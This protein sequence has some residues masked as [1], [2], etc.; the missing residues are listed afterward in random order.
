MLLNSSAIAGCGKNQHLTQVP[1]YISLSYIVEIP[2]MRSAMIE[3]CNSA[4]SFSLVCYEH[5]CFL[6]YL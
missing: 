1:L 6:T 5:H 3:L 4:S 2:T